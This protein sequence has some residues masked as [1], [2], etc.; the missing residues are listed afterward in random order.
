[1]IHEVITFIY[2]F[3][4][5]LI[6]ILFASKPKPQKELTGPKIAIIGAGLTGISAGAHCIGAGSDVVI[7]EKS[8]D[9]GGIW[10]KVNETSGLQIHSMMYRFHPAVKYDSDYPKRKQLVDNIQRIWHE[11]GLDKKT[12]FGTVVESVERDAKSGKWVINGNYDEKFHGVIAAIGTCGDPQF[13]PIEGQDHF[14]GQICHSSE[15]TGV[16]VKGKNLIVIG[17]GASAVEAMEY[18]AANNAGSIKILARVCS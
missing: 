7:F 1:M 2:T 11:Y 13:A 17:G 5:Q 8:E 6:I 18:A 16:D 3:I 12:R 14:S 9:V 4:Q 15:L 10:T